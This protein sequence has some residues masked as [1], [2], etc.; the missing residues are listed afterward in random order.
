MA[1]AAPGHRHTVWSSSKQYHS[2]FRRERGDLFNIG[3]LV[4]YAV[5][6]IDDG[7][8]ALASG[9]TTAAGVNFTLLEATRGL[10]TLPKLRASRSGVRTK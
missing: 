7:Q 10:S 2:S 1:L 5:A 8:G 3:A 9:E 6:F 4:V